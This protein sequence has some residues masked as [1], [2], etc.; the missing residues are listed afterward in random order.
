[1]AHTAKRDAARILFMEGYTRAAIADM[2]KLATRTVN[3]WA[4]DEDW[5]KKRT[6][7]KVYQENSTQTIMKLI[8]QKLELL[9]MKSDAMTHRTNQLRAVI[10]KGE[11]LT[12]EEMTLL[13]EALKAVGNADMDGLNKLYNCIKTDA[14]KWQTYVKVT[15][16]LVEWIGSIDRDFASKLT[17]HVGTFLQDLHHKL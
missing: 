6:E 15:T 12:D 13:N 10:A 3:S 2:L 9:E 1:M 4:N 16:D 7:A 8:H 5:E 11:Q 14:I 17:E